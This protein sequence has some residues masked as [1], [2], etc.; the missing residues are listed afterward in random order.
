MEALQLHF[1]ADGQIEFEE[2]D[3]VANEQALEFR[4]FAQEHS[5]LICCAEAH[6]PFDAGAIVPGAVEEHDFAGRRQVHGVALEIELA[7]FGFGWL[8]ERDGPCM[9][10]V[11]VLVEGLDARAFTGAV[12]AFVEAKQC[13]RRF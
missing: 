8:G 3:A 7:A 13:G 4:R 11:H 10:R 5:K 1:A 6:D 9:A 2:L 12:A